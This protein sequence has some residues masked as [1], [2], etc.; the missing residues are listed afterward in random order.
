MDFTID[1]DD[2]AE[3]DTDLAE[4]VSQNTRRYVNMIADI[5][6]SLIPEYRTREVCVL[7]LRQL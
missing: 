7:V 3:Y 4:A 6:E 1:L 2:L 5:V